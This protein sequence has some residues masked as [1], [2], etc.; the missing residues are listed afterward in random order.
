MA[1]FASLS[2]LPTPESVPPVPTPAT[3]TSTRLVQLVR[4]RDRALHA[5]LAGREHEL[6]AV[7]RRELATLDRHRVGHREDELVAL[8]RGDEREADAGVAARR[9]DERAAR[10][11]DAGLLRRLDH[12]ERDAVLH[13][14]AR[15]EVL[16]LDDHLRGALVELA[17]ADERR[18]AD[19]FGNVFVD[20]GHGVVSVGWF[21]NLVRIAVR[22][23]PPLGIITTISVAN[24]AGV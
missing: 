17:D 19:Q 21:M 12:R 15:V 24:G 7:G 23:G 22:C 10:L 3:K 18:I 1:G 16:D 9:L 5:V 14:P 4:L 2:A 6:R 11:Q 13:G 20:V 8:H